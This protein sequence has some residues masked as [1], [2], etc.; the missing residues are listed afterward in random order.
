[1]E[2]LENVY[3]SENL[4]SLSVIDFNVVCHYLKNKTFK[5]HELLAFKNLDEVSCLWEGEDPVWENNIDYFLEMCNNNVISNAEIE[6]KDK[7]SLSFS[8][9]R[10]TISDKNQET[11][12]L[13]TV[14]ILD[15]YGYFAAQEIWDF[16]LDKKNEVNISQLIGVQST[17]INSHFRK[18]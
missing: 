5:I 9:G 1:L 6:I 8:Y 12:K 18:F 4:I 13:F 15:F 14:K 10:L 17:E 3:I 11:L 2:Y 7:S 16:C